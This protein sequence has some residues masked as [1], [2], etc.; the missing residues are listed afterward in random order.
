LLLAHGPLQLPGED[1]LNGNGLDFFA[2]A[3]FF[4]E[5]IEG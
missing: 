1:A 5:A 2:D 4:E 3:F